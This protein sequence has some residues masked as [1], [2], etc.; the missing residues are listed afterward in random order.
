M[1]TPVTDRSVKVRNEMYYVQIILEKKC[2]VS[3][4]CAGPGIS[5]KLE[6]KKDYLR[7]DSFHSKLIV[8]DTGV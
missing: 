2:P 4:F 5:V 1:M 3:N 8:T 7:K 6:M